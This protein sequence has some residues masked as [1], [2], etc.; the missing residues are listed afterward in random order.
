MDAQDTSTRLVIVSVAIV[1]RG[2]LT[3]VARPVEALAPLYAL[4][5]SSLSTLRLLPAPSDSGAIVI[6][7]LSQSIARH[8]NFSPLYE[9]S[10]RCSHHHLNTLN[11]TNACNPVNN[12]P[13][14]VFKKF[15]ANPRRLLTSRIPRGRD[16]VSR[17]ILTVAN[18]MTRYN[19]KLL[20]RP[21]TNCPTP[22]RAFS[23]SQAQERAG[24]RSARARVP[25][26]SPSLDWPFKPRQSTKQRCV[27]REPYHVAEAPQQTRAPSA[28]QPNRVRELATTLEE[29]QKSVLRSV[30]RRD[31]QFSIPP[32]SDKHVAQ[33]SLLLIDR[34]PRCGCH[35]GQ[36][37]H[38]S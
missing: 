37:F 16:V 20:W 15:P 12:P 38:K 8:Q 24:H 29:W 19:R 22:H 4:P 1:R 33:C 28:E 11:S 25:R 13:E 31:C 35:R 9:T 3:I 2:I 14:G 7:Q 32:Q 10:Y 18:N 27:R 17:A 23:R 30:N 36:R 21:F 5:R 34:S 26:M 6:P